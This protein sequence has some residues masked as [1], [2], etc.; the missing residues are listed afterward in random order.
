MMI[1]ELWPGG[2][3]FKE[4]TGVQRIGADSIL[5]ADFTGRTGTG[6][7]KR[8]A[9]LGCGAGI[10]SILLAWNDPGLHVDAI[11][12]QPHAV[13]LASENAELSGLAGRITIIEGDLRRH[14]DFLQSGAYDITVSNPPYN[15]HGSGKRC[16]NTN[17]AA[18]RDDELYPLD[19]LCNTAGYLT[20]WG[21]SFFLVHRPERLCAVFSSLTTHGLEPKRIRFVQHTPSSPPNLVLIESRRG[22]KP[23]LKVE[24][25]LILANKDGR[26]S[27]EVKAI[28]RIID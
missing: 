18:A 24:A 17:K 15:P 21:G 23:S 20:R 28:Y 22:G 25:P 2:P 9:D 11:E 12:I 3:R 13:K 10:I 19:D 16:V 1:R 26:D 6:K 4:E 27:D 8:A 5:L 14:R 7:S